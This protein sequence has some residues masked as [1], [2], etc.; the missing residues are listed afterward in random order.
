MN[1]IKMDN[2]IRKGQLV[3]WDYGN[4]VFKVVGKEATDHQYAMGN[5]YIVYR[6]HIQTKTTGQTFRFLRRKDIDLIEAGLC[7]P[8]VLS[9]KG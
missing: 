8:A 1:T 9:K 7:S 4:G 2:D 6:Y 3:N 5:E